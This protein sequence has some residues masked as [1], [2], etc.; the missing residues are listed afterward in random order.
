MRSGAGEPKE[1]RPRAGVTS[2]L[3]VPGSTP[4]TGAREWAEINMSSVSKF[5]F[6]AAVIGIIGVT[7]AVGWVLNIVA[8]A[9]MH[10]ASGMM[11][12]RILGVV[13]PPIGAI[14]GW[15]H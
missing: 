3:L 11:A 14:L 12:A 8:L 2:G 10:A 1:S 15:V 13:V 6:G 5:L 4:V 7:A 9:H